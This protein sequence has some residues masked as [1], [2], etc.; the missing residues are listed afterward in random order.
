MTVVT[1][2]GVLAGC[3][4]YTKSD[5]IAGA[6]AICASTTRQTRTVAPPNF[7]HTQAEELSGLGAYLER[8]VPI[9]QSEVAKLRAL[10]NP[11]Q[12]SSDHA[13]LERYLTALGQAVADYR[14]LAVA[15]LRGDTSAAASAE[16]AL[17]ASPVTA[18]AA[19]YGL[20]SCSAPGATVG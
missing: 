4:S 11:S 1:L 17:R 8:V 3:G 14:A 10:R 16:A 9:A 20:R 5:F 2:A 12:S 15:A 18:L 19:S 13:V 7:G 6:D